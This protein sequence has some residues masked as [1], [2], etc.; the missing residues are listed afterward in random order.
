METYTNVSVH[1]SWSRLIVSTRC[2]P[3]LLNAQFK[4][5]STASAS[6]PWYSIKILIPNWAFNSAG[7]HRVEMNIPSWN[8]R[9]GK[10]C[11]EMGFQTS[12][13]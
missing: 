6:W 13:Y 5:H 8:M 12:R 11:E 1:F 3:A 7:L 4:A 9:L 10:V 2:R